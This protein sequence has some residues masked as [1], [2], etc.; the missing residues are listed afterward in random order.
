MLTKKESSTCPLQ[1]ETVILLLICISALTWCEGHLCKKS[2]K[3]FERP[4]ANF[5]NSP[6]WILTFPNVHTHT[7][8][9]ETAE[10]SVFSARRPTICKR[11]KWSKK[12]KHKVDANASPDRS[13][14]RLNSAGQFNLFHVALY[15]LAAFTSFST[16]LP[17]TQLAWTLAPETSGR[18]RTH[19]K[20]L[21]SQF[22]AH[23][24]SFTQI[25]FQHRIP[26]LAFH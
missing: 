7:R 19:K 9:A 26:N 11:M 15:G 17:K 18:L 21:S 25:L 20:E 8:R 4:R 3:N 13:S 6:L 23:F 12:Q 2:P 1:S 14:G 16:T 24:L 5:T 22:S 10:L